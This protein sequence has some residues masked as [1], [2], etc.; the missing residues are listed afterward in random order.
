MRKTA[1]YVA[2]LLFILTAVAIAANQ[3]GVADK[4]E[5]TFYNAVRV[6]DTLLPPGEY[7]VIHQ[8]QGND[9]FMIFTK[10]GKKPAEARVKCTLKPL[11]TQV[12]QSQ[13]E[14]SVNAANERVL[15]RIVFKGDK[16]EH[17]F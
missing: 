6:G 3:Y 11:A 17:L 14:Y 5:V 7:V 1:V 13:T 8:M 9:H 10:T 12:A 2:V 4:R 15:R 16:A